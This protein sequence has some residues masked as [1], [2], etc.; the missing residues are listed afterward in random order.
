MSSEPPHPLHPPHHGEANRLLSILRHPMGLEAVL[1]RPRFSAAQIERARRD[2]QEAAI[3]WANFYDTVTLPLA[4]IPP[5]LS[6]R[7]DTLLASWHALR[8]VH[9]LDAATLVHVLVVLLETVPATLPE[10]APVVP[11]LLTSPPDV[12]KATAAHPRAYQGTTYKPPK[13]RRLPPLDL[14]P[15]LCHS[16]ER[17]RLLRHLRPHL[18]AALAKLAALGYTPARLASARYR[19]SRSCFTQQ[20]VTAPAAVPAL[21]LSLTQRTPSVRHP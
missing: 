14:Q 2:K 9:A 15:A 6:P 12:P 1:N 18:T 8:Q 19:A 16:R 4:R 3:D 7:R 13:P 21:P 17:Q 20:Q 11:L 5:A 10:D